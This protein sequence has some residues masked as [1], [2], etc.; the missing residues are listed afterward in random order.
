MLVNRM[1]PLPIIAALAMGL[2]PAWTDDAIPKALEL[3]KARQYEDAI[4]ELGKDL[5]SKPEA[6][7]GQ[8]QFWTGECHSCSGA[9]T[10]RSHSSSRR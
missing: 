9:T 2:A 8:Q 7:T 6:Q 3:I 10:R 5:G 4:R 1:S